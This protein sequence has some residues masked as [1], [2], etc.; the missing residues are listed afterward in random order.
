LLLLLCWLCPGFAAA[1][2]T[3]RRPNILFLFAD[4]LCFETI[5]AFGHTDIDTP[6]LDKLAAR[7]T[8]FT[9]AYNM[10]S[11]SGAVCVAS[12]TMLISGRSLWNAHAIY[13]RTDH[14]RQAGRLW[15][16]LLKSAGYQTYFTGKWHIRTDAA[17]TFDVAANV[18]GG[19]PRD[20]ETGYNRPRNGQTDRWS[21]SDPQF[22]G[23]W[24]GGRHWSEVVGDDAVGFL[25]Q[26]AQSQ[27]PFFMYIAFNAA[28]DPRQSPKEYIDRYPLERVALPANYL[29]EYPYKEEIGCGTGL[30]DERLAPFPRTARAVQVHRQEYYAL[31]THMDAQI[32]RILDAL[33]QTGEAERTWI[34]FTADHGL[35]V[36][37]HGLMGK[38]NM[39]EHSLRVPFIVNGPGVASQSKVDAPIYLQDVMPTTLE[40]AGV[41]RPQH[42]DFH[43]LLP[44]LNGRSP[45]RDSAVYGAYL[46]LQRAVIHDGWKLI[47]YPRARTVRM[48]HLADDPDERHDLADDPASAAR[49]RQLIQELLRLQQQFADPLDLS[50]FF[51][52]L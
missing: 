2:E 16:Q 46:E 50:S 42:V 18:R 32:G 26:A 9:R 6:N 10:G 27:R 21:P 51:P 1:Q 39:Y 12:R 28:H 48:Y 14:E 3:A 30:R 36:G 44:L 40:L 29:P 37:H 43:S 13:D 19:M 8:T 52:A 20:T 34:F 35:A 7:G 31:I 23:F 22:G 5:R 33:E 49:R 45:P 41:E 38:Q 11:W 47:V 25:A 4:D 15:P 24:E 17:G